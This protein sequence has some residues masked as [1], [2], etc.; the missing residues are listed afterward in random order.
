MKISTQKYERSMKII[1][2]KNVVYDSMMYV[3]IWTGLQY[4]Y[5]HAIIRTPALKINY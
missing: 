4:N 2:I 3:A 1:Y 5:V